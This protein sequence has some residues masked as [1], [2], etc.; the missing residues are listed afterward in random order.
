ME[1]LGREFGGVLGCD[2]FSAYRKFMG[3]FD[4]RVQFCLAHLIRDLRFLTD[5]PDPATRAYGQQILDEVKELFRVFH[6]REKM[7]FTSFTQTL[8]Q[9]RQRILEVAIKQAPSRL[10]A[11][12]KEL[13]REA[14]NM[15]RRFRLHGQ[16]YFQFITTPGIQP[17][18]NLAEQAIRFVVIDRHITQGTRSAK[19]RQTCQRLWSVIATCALQGRSAFEFI[20]QAVQAY[21]RN[22][23]APSLLTAPT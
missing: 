18:N 12:G 14:Q 3:E 17:T 10:N 5:L 1:L 7:S 9:C 15:A 11:Q 16:A 8:N 4:V 2:Y 6:D 22:E 20:L 21:C 23:E 13:C 19:G